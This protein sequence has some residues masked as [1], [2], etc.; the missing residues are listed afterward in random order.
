[1]NVSVEGPFR[2]LRSPLILKIKQRIG[3]KVGAEN[4]EPSFGDV[5]I[6][7]ALQFVT[8]RAVALLRRVE[9]GKPLGW[10][11][12]FGSL[13]QRDAGIGDAGRR[14]DEGRDT[15]R[16]DARPRRLL[17]IDNHRRSHGCFRFGDRIR[18]KACRKIARQGEGGQVET[19]VA[20]ALELCEGRA[21][22][23]GQAVL[24]DPYGRVGAPGVE[25]RDRAASGAPVAAAERIAAIVARDEPPHCRLEGALC[26][27]ERRPDG[28]V[29]DDWRNVRRAGASPGAAAAKSSFGSPDKRDVGRLAA[30]RRARPQTRRATD[31]RRQGRR[32]LAGASGDTI[33]T[34]RR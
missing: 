14:E 13:S 21:A 10:I 15:G 4:A 29:V 26:R 24:A 33:G 2:S 9:V 22:R 6:L 1:M 27:R 7:E 17:G 18:I 19:V 5:R 3:I 30:R 31:L 34:L 32:S 8:Q 20:G 12:R 16:R 23:L 28:R 11:R 25:R